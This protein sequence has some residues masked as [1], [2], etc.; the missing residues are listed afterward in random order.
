VARAGAGIT[1]EGD[2]GERRLLAMPPAEVIDG[3]A[4]A[5]RRVLAEGS[6][7]TGAG[8]IADAMALLPTADAALDVLEATA[9]TAA[10]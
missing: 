5:V 10:A 4:P 1:L 3:L 2:A 7:A 6:Y 9:Q 8:R